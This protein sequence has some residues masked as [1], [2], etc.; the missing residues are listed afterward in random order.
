LLSRS[1]DLRNVPAMEPIL[2]FWLGTAP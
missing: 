1:A 2:R